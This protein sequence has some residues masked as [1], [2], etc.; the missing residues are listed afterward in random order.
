MVTLLEA[1]AGAGVAFS[2]A[3]TRAFSSIAVDSTSFNL[4]SRELEAV[5]ELNGFK[6][7]T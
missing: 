1:A 3:E 5:G 7:L 6:L 4:E 2:K